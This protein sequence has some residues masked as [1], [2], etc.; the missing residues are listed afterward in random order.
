MNGKEWRHEF[1]Y[2]R[3]LHV[4]FKKTRNTIRDVKH[5]TELYEW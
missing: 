4:L 5:R 3:S 2:E 1:N